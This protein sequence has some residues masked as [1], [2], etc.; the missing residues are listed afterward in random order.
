[1]R[2]LLPFSILLLG[3]GNVSFKPLNYVKR[4]NGFLIDFLRDA[5]IKKD[6]FANEAAFTMHKGE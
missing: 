2:L 3:T 4:A 6:Q 5:I 1:M